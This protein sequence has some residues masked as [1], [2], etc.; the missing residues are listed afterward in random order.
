MTP[1][2]DEKY[3][4]ERDE[5]IAD[6]AEIWGRGFDQETCMKKLSL[7]AADWATEYWHKRMVPVEVCERLVEALKYYNEMNI[8][9]DQVCCDNAQQVGEEEWCCCGQ[10]ITKADQ[11]L[12]EF[13]KYKEGK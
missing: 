5:K 11:A 8:S 6:L 9:N 4:A 2:D 12:A 3:R 10:P 1:T 7:L 13:E